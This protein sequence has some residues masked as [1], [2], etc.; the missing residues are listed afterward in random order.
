[1]TNR[2][3]KSYFTAVTLVDAGIECQ[4]QECS[5]Q[6]CSTTF[7]LRTSDNVL[8]KHLKNEHN[9]FSSNNKKQAALDSNA[10]LAV[11]PSLNLELS[12]GQINSVVSLIED[13]Y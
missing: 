5:F 6:G 12:S 7:S 9:L 11:P 3:V 13:L 1:M 2:T 4:R 10:P 8:K